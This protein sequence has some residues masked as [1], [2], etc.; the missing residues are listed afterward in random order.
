[1]MGIDF[2]GRNKAN[3]FT[4]IELMIVVAIVSILATVAYPAYMQ[5]VVKAKRS[6]AQSFMMSVANKQEQFMLDSRSYAS[7]PN[8]LNTLQLAV[9]ADVSCCYAISVAASSP[10]PVYRITAIPTGSQL[11]NDAKCGSLTLD[12]AGQKSIGGTGAVT[13]CW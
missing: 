9:P 2:D 8:A 10:P 4:L 7:D 6:A 11:T 12:Q 3:G 5:Y 1:M 13:E